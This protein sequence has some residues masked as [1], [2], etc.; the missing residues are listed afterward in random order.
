MIW[1]TKFTINDLNGSDSESLLTNLG[2]EFTEFGDQHL[3]ASMPVDK[4][5][6]QPY[7]ILHGGASATL[8]ETV[9][10]VASRLCLDPDKNLVPV[11]IELNIS[12]LKSVTK[13]KVTAI[14]NPIRLGKSLHVWNIDIKNE[15]GKAIS[16]A[17]L[18]TM[19]IKKR[20][21]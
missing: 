10:S 2:I 21:H 5:T 17:R 9:G 11:G 1:K 20:I 13:G 7:G 4:R 19:I 18:T 15:E 3:S 8:A 12:H 14:A 6:I 16:S